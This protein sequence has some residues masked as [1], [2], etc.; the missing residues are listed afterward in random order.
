MEV[1]IG[2]LGGDD[3]D[4]VGQACIERSR[5]ALERRP[6]VDVDGDDVPKGVY[7]GVGTPGDREPVE[8][9][10]RGGQGSTDGCLDGRE[11]GLR[12]PPPE[13]RAVVLDRQSEAHVR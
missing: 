7:T 11:T 1:R 8:R 9:V 2:R 3:R 12:G 4:L 6:S 5:G 10:E 13:G